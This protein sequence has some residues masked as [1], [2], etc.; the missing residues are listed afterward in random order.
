M[1]SADILLIVV[2]LVAL[3][4]LWN[5]NGLVRSRMRT[6]EA[7]SGI[8]VQLKRRADLVPNLVETVRSYAA[9]ERQTFEEV[10]QARSAVHQAQ[11]PAQATD[12]HAK[13]TEGLARLFAIAEAYPALRA[14][15]NFIQLQKELSDVEEKIAYARQ[16]YNRNILDYNT[17][18]NIFPQNLVAQLFDFQPAE[19]FETD[20]ASRDATKVDFREE[21]E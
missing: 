17:R 2:A 6:R 8:D 4:V 15:E 7:W 13:L 14:S 3:S 9:H 16:F 5:Y 12:A 19:F 21:A 1:D 11:G 10:A 20:E 18:V